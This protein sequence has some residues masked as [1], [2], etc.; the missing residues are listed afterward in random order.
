[1]SRLR[2]NTIRNRLLV[3]FFAIASAAVVFVY[4]YVVPQLQSSLTTQKLRRLESVGHQ[5][6]ATLVAA[7]RRG[8]APDELRRVVARAAQESG[9]RVTIVAVKTPTAGSIPTP[10]FIVADSQI[11]TGTTPPRFPPVAGAVLTAHAAAGTER[12]AGARTA[13]IAVPLYPNG[14]G[15]PLTAGGGAPWVA[16]FSSSLADVEANVALIKRQILIAGAIALLAALAAG[17]FASQAISGRL[18]RLEEAAQQV[19]EGDFSVHIPVDSSDELGELART[20]NEMQQRLARL[21]NARKEFIAN[22]SH[23]LRTPIFSLG[24]FV[25]LLGENPDRKTR[26]E[27]VRTMREQIERLRKLTTDLLDLS[28]L[29]AGALEL[30]SEEVDLGALAESL[31]GEFLPVASEHG[32]RLELRAAERPAVARADPDRVGQIIRILLSNALTHTP[33][34]TDVTLTT[35]SENGTTRLIVS[36]AGPGIKPR[37]AERVFERFYTGDSATGSG[38]G[39]AIARELALRMEGRLDV[40]SGKGYTAFTLELPGGVVA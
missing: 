26:D 39:L 15:I 4:L 34:G 11:S 6:A 37:S 18:R 2:L 5:Q 36:D 9:A 17:Y 27:F 25:E 38:L 30:R 10:G 32:S 28:K 40:S 33:E 20:F 12:I 35:L 31:A 24:G 13:E 7:M 29:D 1:V 3:L 23:E 19:A 14:V 16:V 22:A 8:A 21:D